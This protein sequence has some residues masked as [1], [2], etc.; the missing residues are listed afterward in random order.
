ME[1]VIALLVVEVILPVIALHGTAEHLVHGLGKPYH[2]VVSSH[3]T[4]VTH[5]SHIEGIKA[6]RLVRLLRIIVIVIGVP[7]AHRWLIVRVSEL[8]VIVLPVVLVG[9]SSSVGMV[10]SGLRLLVIGVAVRVALVESGELVADSIAV[11]QCGVVG[12]VGLYVVVVAVESAGE[13]SLGCVESVV[14]AVEVE[15]GLGCVDEEGVVVA[16]D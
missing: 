7:R 14:V 12:V 2:E 4:T 16:V 6:H 1:I 15:G 11:Q 5:I 10:V 8:W 13:G 9:L 3:K